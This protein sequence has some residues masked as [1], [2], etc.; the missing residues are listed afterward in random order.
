MRCVEER[1]DASF[2]E[3]V[4][5]RIRSRLLRPVIALDFNCS[6]VP[7]DPVPMEFAQ[8]NSSLFHTSSNREAS[9]DAVVMVQ[10]FANSSIR[11][12]AMP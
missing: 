3:R 8:L 2:L 10:Y 1:E 11:C 9:I 12:S 7:C 4:I 6:I 5:V